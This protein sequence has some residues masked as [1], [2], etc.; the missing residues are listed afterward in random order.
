MKTGKGRKDPEQTAELTGFDAAASEAEVGS[1]GNGAAPYGAD[2]TGGRN[3]FDEEAHNRDIDTDQIKRMAGEP[4]ED[5]S[6]IS[7]RPSDKVDTDL[8]QMP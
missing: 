3:D 8:S 4:E 7:A 2:L 5:D 1:A 6:E